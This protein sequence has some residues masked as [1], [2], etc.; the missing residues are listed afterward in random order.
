M[1]DKVL[2]AMRTGRFSFEAISDCVQTVST[3]NKDDHETLFILY[4][5]QP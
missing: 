3:V 5:T 1:A 4:Y 2:P